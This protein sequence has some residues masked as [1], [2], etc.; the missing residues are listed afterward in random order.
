M[1]FLDLFATQPDESQRLRRL[2]RQVAGR[3]AREKSAVAE[4]R[5]LGHET[6]LL[7]LVELTLIKLLAEKGVIKEREFVERLLKLDMIDGAADGKIDPEMLRKALGLTGGARAK[8]RQKPPVAR[9]VNGPTAAGKRAS[10]A[11]RFAAGKPA[12]KAASRAKPPVRAKASAKPEAE[13]E[14][15]EDL[16]AA[17]DTS[18][19]T[20]LDTKD[21]GTISYE[22]YF[23]AEDQK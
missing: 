14:P 19:D 23:G 12:K 8:P 6:G 7:A 18:I 16:A 22:D 13:P 4:A 17:L 21:L 10:K 9:R 1:D 3:T 5:R 2:S 15:V 20:S 11:A